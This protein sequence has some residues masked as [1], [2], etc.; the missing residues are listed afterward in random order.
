MTER[1]FYYEEADWG[2]A[3]GI[4]MIVMGSAGADGNPL[5]SDE[6]CRLRVA[7]I[8]DDGLDAVLVRELHVVAVS[9]THLDVYKRQR[10]SSGRRRC[11]E[12]PR[13]SRSCR[14]NT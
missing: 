5:V 2:K 14:R 13:E 11:W 4:V 8:D 10:C 6:L 7:R 12:G 1:R 3:I 9:Y